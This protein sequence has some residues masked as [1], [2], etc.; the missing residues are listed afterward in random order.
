M[1]DNTGKT[2]PDER[3]GND[4]R[5]L[6]RLP[7]SVQTVWT[8]MGERAT[9]LG[10]RIPRRATAL[11]IAATMSA[12]AVTT[13]LAAPGTGSEAQQ[14][15]QQP[16][17]ASKPAAQGPEPAQA[18]APAAPAAPKPEAK[19]ATSTVQDRIVDAARAE[20]G[21]METGGENCQKYSDQCVA[22]CALFAT[23]MWESAGVDVENE[24]FAFTGN[25]YTTGQE[26]GTAYDS[27]SLDQAKPGD[28]LLFG[29]GPSSPSTSS[30]IGVVEKVEGN[31]VTL[32]EGNAGDNTDS[33]VRKQHELSDA[34]FY[35]GVH[36]W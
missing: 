17:A 18:P 10:Q 21:T 32:I 5:L 35:G 20:L 23:S 31:T 9:S 15:A 12:A 30:H 34:T 4:K 16:P 7:Q 14:A 36:P 13:A 29:T 27:E 8:H 1:Q 26:K 28:V 33:V 24:D 11:G 22:W 2:S 25:V 6:N 3:P 19:Q